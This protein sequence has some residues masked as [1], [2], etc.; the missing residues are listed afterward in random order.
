MTSNGDYSQ[1]DGITVTI[2]YSGENS[3]YV[4]KFLEH[5][6]SERLNLKIG[7]RVRCNN[8]D[9]LLECD[10]PYK[11]EAFNEAKKIILERIK[12]PNSKIRSEIEAPSFITSFN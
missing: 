3:A 9:V 2:L 5:G 12:K 6:L 1:K 10:R 11:S 7:F 4:A 8:D